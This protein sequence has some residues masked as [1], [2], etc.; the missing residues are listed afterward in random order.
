MKSI[1]ALFILPLI[2]FFALVSPAITQAENPADESA[3]AEAHPLL[4]GLDRVMFLGDSIT[5]DGR[6]VAYLHTALMLLDP[7]AMAGVEFLNLG[8]SA[9]TVSGLTEK[10]HG[11]PRPWALD[12]ID[13]ALEQFQP[14]LTFVC[15]GM[16]DGIYHPQSEERFDAFREGIRAVIEKLRASG[17][18]V[19]LITPPVFD[20]FSS[21]HELRDQ[22][23]EDYGYRIPY[24]NYSSVLQEYGWWIL[25]QHDG[26]F[27]TVD[28]YEP[29]ARYIEIAREQDPEFKFGDGVHPGD[30]GHLIMALSI[31]E[32]LDLPLPTP[33]EAVLNLESGDGPLLATLQS[34]PQ[35]LPPFLTWPPD[36]DPSPFAT[37]PVFV[38]PE[39]WNAVERVTITETREGL[40]PASQDVPVV[41]QRIQTDL[42]PELP[43]NQQRIA[44]HQ[45]LLEMHRELS[46][47][48][49]AAVA[50]DAA[51]DSTAA[52]AAAE[53][54]EARAAARQQLQ[55]GAAQAAPQALELRISP[56]RD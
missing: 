40:E 37:G 6:Y 41:R 16:N 9:E 12:R 46:R 51:P 18:L 38:L 11:N 42:A 3:A 7:E 29:L 23:A 14:Q 39:A 1:H 4:G 36:W 49:R 26:V 33:P 55:R 28:I 53:L 8:L 32:A 19:V 25:S 13:A 21:P 31:L 54:T 15:Y 30:D 20:A 50:A 56:I 2:A 10:T 35:T 47:A 5:Q 22:G 24:R 45:T 48:G 52:A 17:S 34:A 27:A 43:L 44:V